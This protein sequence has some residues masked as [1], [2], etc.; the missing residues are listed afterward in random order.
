MVPD[1]NF[2]DSFPRNTL[3][4]PLDESIFNNDVSFKKGSG[5][6]SRHGPSGASHSWCLT[7][8]SQALREK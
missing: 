4:Q 2:A 3:G 7:P 6:N 8:F 5:T 1:F